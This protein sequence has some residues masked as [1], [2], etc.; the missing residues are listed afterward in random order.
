ML[1]CRKCRWSHCKNYSTLVC[2][3]MAIS[4]VQ[5]DSLMVCTLLVNRPGRKGSGTD[6]GS[7]RARYIHAEGLVLVCLF[8]QCTR[9]TAAQSLREV[10]AYQVLWVSSAG[11]VDC[12]I[13]EPT[14]ICG[15]DQK[16]F[17]E[18]YYCMHAY[19]FKEKM[20]AEYKFLCLISYRL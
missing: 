19:V 6:Y 12:R 14:A 20:M 16:L 15:N 11:W 1:T 4:D 10:M 9:M 8:L 17:S 13:Q 2:S 18:L 7:A 5:C 3:G